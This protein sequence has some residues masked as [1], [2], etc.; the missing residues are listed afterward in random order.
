MRRRS[1]REIFGDLIEW[2]EV[3]QRAAAQDRKYV[4]QLAQFM[5]DWEPKAIRAAFR[6][7]SNTWT[8]SNRQMEREPRRRRPRRRRPTHDRARR[9]RP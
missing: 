7:S 4:N 8:I 3:P 2:L 5:K 6:S 9:E 1:A